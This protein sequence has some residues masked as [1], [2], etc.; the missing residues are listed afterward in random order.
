M[1]QCVSGAY[2]HEDDSFVS[3]RQLLE[4]YGKY[5]YEARPDRTVQDIVLFCK[6]CKVLPSLRIIFEI[7]VSTGRDVWTQETSKSFSGRPRRRRALADEETEVW[8]D[9]N[10][11][12]E[13]CTRPGGKSAR[14]SFDSNHANNTPLFRRVRAELRGLCFEAR[15]S[16]VATQM[17]H[18]LTQLLPSQMMA[19]LW[20][21]AYKLDGS[22]V[23]DVLRLEDRL[24]INRTLLV[25][26]WGCLHPSM[27]KERILE[28][29]EGYARRHRCGIWAFPKETK[30]F[31][32]TP[33]KHVPRSRCRSLAESQ[34]RAHLYACE[35]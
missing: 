5:L 33:R 7:P 21:S 4:R 13:T 30:S 10:E 20:I 29:L 15:T 3:M 2:N 28:E 32:S 16:W 19:Q 18:V 23:A 31:N 12:V 1:G 6:V 24:H 25:T 22:V 27:R 11:H 8:I 14:L 26:G 17:H 34:H 35:Q 9:E